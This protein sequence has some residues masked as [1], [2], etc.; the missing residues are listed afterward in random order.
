MTRSITPTIS[1]AIALLSLPL[2]FGVYS[3]AEAQ[4]RFTFGSVE[5][6]PYDAR[7]SE[8][9]TFIA[10]EMP[11]GTP[12]QVAVARLNSA[13]ASCA[14]QGSSNGQ[15]QC[16]FSSVERPTEGTLGEVTWQVKLSPDDQGRVAAATVE[17]TRTGFGDD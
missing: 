5:Y 3:P 10:D 6:E 9:R 8:A 2:T 1:A 12:I 4:G 15:I 7:L 14:N 17:R 11:V 16:Q 13:D